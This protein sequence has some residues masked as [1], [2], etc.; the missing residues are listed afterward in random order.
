MI[1]VKQYIFNDEIFVSIL[2]KYNTA[3]FLYILLSKLIFRIAETIF[4]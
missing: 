2:H 1:L 3:E 4:S